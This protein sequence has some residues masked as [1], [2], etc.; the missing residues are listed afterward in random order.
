VVAQSGDGGLAEDR[1]SLGIVGSGQIPS[2]QAKPRLRAA[3]FGH[4]AVDIEKARLRLAKRCCPLPTRKAVT[5]TQRMALER[6]GD[7]VVTGLGAVVRSN[8]NGRR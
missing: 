7:G 6:I 4:D 5:S 8:I 3:G 1:G 2:H